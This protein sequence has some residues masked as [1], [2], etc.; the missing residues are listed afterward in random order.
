MINIVPNSIKDN[1]TTS[2]ED[3]L[4]YRLKGIS[5]L[6]LKVWV[7]TEQNPIKLQMLLEVFGI[8]ATIFNFLYLSEASRLALFRTLLEVMR[9]SGTEWSIINMAKALGASDA[10]ITYAPSL[11]RDGT[12]HYNAAYTHGFGSYSRFSI[13][14]NVQGVPV[15]LRTAF[16]SNFR[17]LMTRWQPVRIH[18]NEVVFT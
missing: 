5:L 17:K 15:H 1:R 18:L 9:F 4:L 11:H 13:T 12:A 7:T 8:D 10:T 14:V 3:T 2:Y 6:Q 16:E